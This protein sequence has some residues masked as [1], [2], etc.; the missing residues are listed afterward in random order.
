MNALVTLKR[1]TRQTW[2]GVKCNRCT[3]KLVQICGSDEEERGQWKS[4]YENSRDSTARVKHI[5]GMD[6]EEQYY[7]SMLVRKPNLHPFI[8][9]NK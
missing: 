4:K 3:W 2:T 6:Q 1:D 7:I 9:I 8:L 5:R